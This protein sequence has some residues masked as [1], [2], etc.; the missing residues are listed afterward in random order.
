M[1]ILFK[2]K[3][4]EGFNTNPPTLK[5]VPPFIVIGVP[6]KTV[7]SW[8]KEVLYNKVRKPV[9]KSNNTILLLFLLLFLLFWGMI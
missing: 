2:V 3:S 5:G 8:E 1:L 6:Y 4:E 7:S 9:F